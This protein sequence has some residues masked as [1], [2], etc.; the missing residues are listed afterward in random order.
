MLSLVGITE[1]TMTRAEFQ[2]VYNQ[3]PDATFALFQSMQQALALLNARVNELEA[4]LSK[5]SHNSSR[6]PSQDGLVRKPKSLRQKS[7]LKSGGQPG[8]P[9]S[10]LCLSEQPDEVVLYSPSTCT[11]CGHCLDAVPI[12]GFERRQVYDL[13]PLLLWITEHRVEEKVCPHCHRHTPRDFPAS[14]SQTVQYG[15]RVKALCVYL[16]QYQLLPFGR[17]QQLIADLFGGSLCEGTLSRCLSA[18]HKHLAPVEA[19][20]QQALQNASVAH[21]DETGVRIQK[22]LHWL[23]TASTPSLT[24]LAPHAKRGRQALDAIGILPAFGGTA[25]HDAFASYF[26]Y[27]CAHALCNAHLLR[28]LLFIKEQTQQ[29]WAEKMIALLLSIKKTVEATKVCGQAT[30]VCGQTHLPSKAINAFEEQYQALVEEGFT[31]NPAVAPSGKRGRT[32]KSAARNLLERL[33]VHRKAVLAFMYD[34]AVPF[35]NNLAERDLRMVKVQQKVSGC[36]RS[37]DGAEIFCR[38]RGYISTLRKQGIPVLSA[39]QSA[40]EGNPIC[41]RLLAE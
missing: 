3:G 37:E 31:A 39:L 40:L 33:A 24:F 11:G 19:S 15:G 29:P 8:H 25:V 16:Q 38:I 7:G 35:D 4:C 36:F 34:F 9:G 26:G 18:C 1:T 21:F 30:K 17:T 10:T 6:P 13:P 12:T 14:V 27:H 5:D 23:H 32:K 22:K 2:S 41:P 28:D 20:I